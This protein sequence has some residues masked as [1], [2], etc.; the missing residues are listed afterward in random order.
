MPN[1][2][3]K[4]T[5]GSVSRRSAL[6]SCS[7]NFGETERVRNH[8]R[9]AGRQELA[10]AC[11]V[12]RPD[13]SAAVSEMRSGEPAGG[14]WSRSGGTRGSRPAGARSARGRGSPQ[15]RGREHA[16][17][18]LH[19]LPC[20]S[21]GIAAG[22]CR[23]AT[24]LGRRDRS[25]VRAVRAFALVPVRNKAKGQSLAH[26]WPFEHDDVA[27]ATSLGGGGVGSPALC[28]CAAGAG[29]FH[30]ASSRGASGDDALVLGTTVAFDEHAACAGVRRGRA[31]S[32]RESG[33]APG[34]ENPPTTLDPSSA[35]RSSGIQA[36]AP[37]NGREEALPAWTTP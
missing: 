24:L 18:S 31:G 36:R 6:S 7:E 1:P 8:L 12:G 30:L 37:P 5:R 26:R 32:V 11:A 9:G 21:D 4:M 20:D 15:S 27:G 29:P 25:G 16:S 35:R 28:A 22:T 13:S 14:R 19:V 2:R 10:R 23:P 17:I 3:G 33:S 34:A